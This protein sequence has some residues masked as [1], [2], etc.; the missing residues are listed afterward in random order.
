MDKKY[1]DERIIQVSTSVST[2]PPEVFDCKWHVNTETI[3]ETFLRAWIICVVVKNTELFPN[4]H[5]RS[6]NEIFFFL[7]KATQ[8]RCHDLAESFQVV[9]TGFAL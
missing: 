8:M 6:S 2:G 1:N 3:T 4:R 9:Y 7:H 5:S